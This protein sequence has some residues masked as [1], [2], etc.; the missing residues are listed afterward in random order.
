MSTQSDNTLKLKTD[1]KI[2][3]TEKTS[4]KQYFQFP[5]ALPS[6][7]LQTMPI[8]DLYQLSL[9]ELVFLQPTL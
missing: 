7:Q 6:L 5:P 2:K 8:G 9:G 3:C 1:L 4:L